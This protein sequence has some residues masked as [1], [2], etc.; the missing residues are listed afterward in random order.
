MSIELQFSKVKKSSGDGD[1]CTKC[2]YSLMA[3]YCT[4]ERV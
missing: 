1:G 3:L 4:L 2:D